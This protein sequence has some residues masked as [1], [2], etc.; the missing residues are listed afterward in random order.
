MALKKKIKKFAR[1]YKIEE[2]DELWLETSL[3]IN[4]T[5]KHPEEFNNFIGE[6]D[7]SIQDKLVENEKFL[8]LSKKIFENLGEFRNYWTYKF[9]KD[10]LIPG[11]L[12]DSKLVEEINSISLNIFEEKIRNWDN[13][14]DIADLLQTL[15]DIDYKE[16]PFLLSKLELELFEEKIRRWYYYPPFWISKEGAR[17]YIKELEQVLKDINYPYLNE[18]KELLKPEGLWFLD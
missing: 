7:W 4:Y 3:F 6:L 14:W 2:S 16:L 5:E 11:I 15:K 18:L 9:Y 8:S 13:P 1:E 17:K 10:K 12:K